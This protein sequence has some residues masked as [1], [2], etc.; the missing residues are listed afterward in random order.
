MK[1]TK[2]M[3]FF[4]ALIMTAGCEINL[5][6]DLLKISI[7]ESS[8]DEEH[9]KKDE[10]YQDEYED[11]KDI[12]NLPEFEECLEL[13]DEELVDECI[14]ELYKL[15]EEDCDKDDYEDLFEEDYE[16]EELKAEFCQEDK[17]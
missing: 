3:L 1:P 11:E 16:D 10:D 7:N 5:D 14:D 13:E 4:V 9:Q 6:E 8:E 12:E 15:Y 17:M 2:Q